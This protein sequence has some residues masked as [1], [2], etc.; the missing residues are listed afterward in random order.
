MN[1]YKGFTVL[2]L[3]VTLAVAAILMAIATPATQLW[4]AN[5][6]VAAIANSLA[7]D[8]KRTRTNAMV[9]RRNH[10]FKALNATVAS[11]QWGKGGWQATQLIG[12]D[13][14]VVE[15]RGVP[16]SVTISGGP[17]ADSVKAD[18][19]LDSIVIVGSTGMLQQ[20]DATALNMV[21]KVCDTSTTKEVG[22]NILINQ[23]GRLLVK[24]HLSSNDAGVLGDSQGC[25]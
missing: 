2:E 12:T 9:T 15:E 7:A 10:T 8:L 18:S 14:M 24:K 23:F 13:Q 3:M 16:A 22:Y 20:A 25:K 11:N 1:N 21:F 19:M 4:Q 6:R 5:A 17:S